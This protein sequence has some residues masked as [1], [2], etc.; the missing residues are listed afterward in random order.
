[1]KTTHVRVATEQDLQELTALYQ[2]FH[3]FHVA[4]VPQRLRVP[5]HYDIERIQAA[6]KEYIQRPDTGLFVTEIDGKLVGFVEVHI[7]EDA[8][9]AAVVAQRYGH[10]QSLM[11]TATHRKVGLGR[12]LLDTAKDW[13]TAQGISQLRLDTWEFAAGPLHFYE[14]LGFR[15]VKREMAL[16]ITTEE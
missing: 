11:V 16:D 2:A 6:L 10:V 14:H 9:D 13:V 15:T 12:A 7:Q 5:E 1:M 8:T 3:E 4:G